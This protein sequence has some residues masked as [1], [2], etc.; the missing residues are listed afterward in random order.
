MY[1]RLIQEKIRQAAQKYP[2]I[3]L[4]GP[5]Q[6]GKTTLARNLFPDYQ[7]VSLEDPDMRLFATEDP[8]GFF[9]NWSQSLILDEVQR[10][11]SILSYLQGR[12]DDPNQ[13]KKYL[14]TGSQN[15]L[16]M[17]SITQSLAG[18]TRIF[19]L[20][21]FSYPEISSIFST[22]TLDEV[23]Y[24]GGYP[25]IFDHQLDPTEWHQEYF[26]TYVERDIRSLLRINEIDFFERF[27]RLCAGRIGQLV[28]L[29]SL[30]NDCGISQPT[31]QSWL[32]ALKTSFICF[33]L[34]PHFKNFNKRLIKTPKVY[35]YD[36]G[37]LCYLLKITQPDHLRVHPLRGSIFENWVISEK[38]KACFNLGIEPSYYFWRDQKG[39]EIDLIRDDGMNL[40]PI[41]IK[42]S[43]T[44]NSEYVKNL[45]YF[46]SLQGTT[47]G[48]CIYGGD[49]SFSFQKYAV[50]SWR[51]S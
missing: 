23:L 46:N 28:N 2:I 48:E 24:L 33:S 18:R 22:K 51:K 7:Y 8:R 25:R 50:S 29:S 34:S 36:T 43:A 15:L 4:L 17:E 6:S 31:A 47:E 37:L 9:Q 39:N 12:V 44:F 35:F 14:L 32:S 16:L 13:K 41:E 3:T 27:V 21:P 26:R 38:L 10:V 19:E 20:L 42:S 30:G 5:R 40:F 1:P 45:N 11:P 49:E